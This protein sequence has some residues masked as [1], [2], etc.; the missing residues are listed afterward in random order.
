MEAWIMCLLYHTP[1]QMTTREPWKHANN[2]STAT[3]KPKNDLKI[4]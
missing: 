2:V 3:E 4:S 1:L